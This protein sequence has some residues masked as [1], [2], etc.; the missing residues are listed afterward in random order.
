[1]G[2]A[3]GRAVDDGTPQFTIRVRRAVHLARASALADTEPGGTIDKPA[4][5]GGARRRREARQV[6]CAVAVCACCC[7][8]A[9]TR[10]AANADGRQRTPLLRLRHSTRL[11]RACAWSPTQLCTRRCCKACV[12]A[13]WAG[14]AAPACRCALRHGLTRLAAFVRFALATRCSSKKRLSWLASPALHKLS[15]T[16]SPGRQRRHLH[17][18]PSAQPAAPATS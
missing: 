1:M 14:C 16:R 4:T 9:L 12:L 7:C 17:A 6:C 18:A 5:V 13:R 3:Q 15:W 10:T 2:A 8:T 11:P